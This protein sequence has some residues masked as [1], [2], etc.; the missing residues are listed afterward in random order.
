MRKRAINNF[1]LVTLAIFAGTVILYGLLGVIPSEGYNPSD[2]GVILAQ[3]YRVLLGQ[4]PHLDFI[5]IRPVGSAILHSVHFI[6]PFPLEISARWL[7][8][9]QYLSYSMVWVW[10][11]VRFTSIRKYRG[12]VFYIILGI[13]AFLLNQNHYNLFPWTTIDALFWIMLVLSFYL[14]EP[15]SIFR[16]NGFLKVFLS[17]FFA[18]MAALSRQTFLLPALVL[19]GGF[20]YH[21]IRSGKVK[22]LVPAMVLGLLP[23]AVYFVILSANNAVPLFIDQMTGRTELYDTGIRKFYLEFWETP[24]VWIYLG[25]FLFLIIYRLT[26]P[27]NTGAVF[28]IAILPVGRIV[29]AVLFLA[30]GITV[31]FRPSI[32]FGLSFFQFW[33]LA[34]LWVFEEVCS[35][36]KPQQRNWFFWILFVSWIS[37]ISL[38]DNAPVFAFGLL[39]V[40]GIGY[41]ILKFSERGFSF[42]K[43]THLQVFGGII[44]VATIILSLRA[45]KEVNYRDLPSSGQENALGVL[46]PEFGRVRT[47]P[48]TFD[49]FRE[50]DRLYRELGF[51]KGRFVVLPNSAI[52]YPVI[53]TP[54]PMPVDWMQAPE[55]VGSEELVKEMVGRAV[56]E[57]EVYFLIDKYN[58]K[59]FADTITPFTPVSGK[60]PYMEYLLDITKKHKLYSDWFDIRVS[61]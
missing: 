47:N 52:V 49:Y 56:K 48:N 12:L 32:I 16:K 44:L 28:R 20:I 10:V 14:P 2:D 22:V 60:Y 43:L 27:G 1:I 36:V 8:L 5:S 4:V 51:P 7:V 40:T 21:G 58:S 34:L 6:S 45:Q 29:F 42:R 54:N 38:G 37:A 30:S 59:L 55:F 25:I 15:Y 11:L 26:Q 53:G 46:F 41:V 19:Y 13:W 35:K 23:Y 39:N 50:I 24:V 3:S 61:K 31:F 18:S 57:Q 17:V 9:L 33:L